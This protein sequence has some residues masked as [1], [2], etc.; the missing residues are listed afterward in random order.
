[1]KTKQDFSLC[2]LLHYR[3]DRDEILKHI[4]RCFNERD[5]GYEQFITYRTADSGFIDMYLLK[6]GFVLVA[7]IREK[8]E[9]YKQCS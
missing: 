9:E 1:M 8:N 5:Y 3:E 2:E 6:D 4:V 7:M